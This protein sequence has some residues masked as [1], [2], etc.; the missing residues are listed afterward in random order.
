ML[1]GDVHASIDTVIAM[2]GPNRQEQVVP[3]A[4]STAN[5]IEA[6]SN[7]PTLKEAGVDATLEAWN[8][9]YA[10]RATPAAVVQALNRA[11]I[12]ALGDPAI[13]AMLVHDG[14]DP[15]GGPPEDLAAPMRR[16]RPIV[17]S[18]GLAPQ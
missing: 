11:A 7:M 4:V 8:A 17:R 15:M 14:A 5:R 1:R 13:K 6:L 18:L 16:D 10:P 2:L 3:I 12:T 9:L